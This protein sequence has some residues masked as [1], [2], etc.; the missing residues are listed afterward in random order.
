MENYYITLEMVFYQLS[1][2]K[3]LILDLTLHTSQKE[4]SILRKEKRDRLES[5]LRL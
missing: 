4:E 2:Y 3:P 1:V 5:F